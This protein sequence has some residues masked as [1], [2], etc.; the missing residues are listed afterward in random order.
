MITLASIDT[1]GVSLFT[2]ALIVGY[3]FW[4]AGIVT[5]RRGARSSV[6]I[7]VMTMVASSIGLSWRMQNSG[8]ALRIGTVLV[9]LFAPVGELGLLFGIY[10]ATT[11][12]NAFVSNSASVS[13]TF[14]IA[15]VIAR[16]RR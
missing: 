15:Y 10:I 11:V 9:E 16:T 7:S 12:L 5:R 3:I 2:L 8:L 1:I 13:L 4:L 14:P 6:D